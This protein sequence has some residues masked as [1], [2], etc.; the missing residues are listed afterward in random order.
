MGSTVSVNDRWVIVLAPDDRV[1]GAV[2]YRWEAVAKGQRVQ[3]D[4]GARLPHTVDV[5][6]LVWH[7]ADCCGDDR[8]SCESEIHHEYNESSGRGTVLTV[9]SGVRGG[10]LVV[11]LLNDVVKWSVYDEQWRMW[12]L[13]V[14]NNAEPPPG[15][16]HAT[17]W[18]AMWRVLR[19]VSKDRAAGSFDPRFRYRPPCATAEEVVGDHRDIAGRDHALVVQ[20]TVPTMH[21]VQM[22]RILS[23]LQRAACDH[24]NVV[25]VVDVQRDQND[26]HIHT[27]YTRWYAGGTLAGSPEQRFS[28][29]ELW[30]ILAG[31]WDGLDELHRCLRLHHGGLCAAA[32]WVDL[33]AAG[34]PTGVL[35]DLDS[36]AAHNVIERYLK[37]G[38]FHDDQTALLRCT[39]DVLRRLPAADGPPPEF[40]DWLSLSDPGGRTTYGD[41]HTAVV[42][43]LRQVGPFPKP[44]DKNASSTVVV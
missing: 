14:E 33:P 12:P 3:P 35:G 32:I 28:A 13:C 4:I 9:P 29:R 1:S 31:A 38:S 21:R 10:R 25:N 19:S 36:V 2:R 17:L 22:T 11:L 34:L 39:V 42:T 7:L 23:T 16:S 44:V 30:H 40:E 6:R 27:Y 18:A 20:H 43:R 8:S 26:I 37:G 24:T 5:V 41:R 15:L